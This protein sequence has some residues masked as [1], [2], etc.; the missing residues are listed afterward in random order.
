MQRISGGCSGTHWMTRM[1]SIVSHSLTYSR[2]FRTPLHGSLEMGDES[3]SNLL[4]KAG[5]ST[6][7]QSGVAPG[8]VR[9]FRS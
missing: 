9:A 5:A 7:A 4:L 1:N 3:M 6:V 8:D 2:Y